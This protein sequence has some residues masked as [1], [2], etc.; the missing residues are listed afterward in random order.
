MSDN[1]QSISAIGVYENHRCARTEECRALGRCAS[2]IGSI[3]ICQEQL[4]PHRQNDRPDERAQNAHSN[5]AAYRAESASEIA[6]QSTFSRSE[7]SRG[8]RRQNA[9]DLPE[10]GFDD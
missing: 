1:S 3:S 6:T 5:E 9:A 7:S 2:C 4:V 10:V 8:G